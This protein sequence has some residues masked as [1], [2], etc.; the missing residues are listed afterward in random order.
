MGH[1][2]PVPSRYPLSL[3]GGQYKGGCIPQYEPQVLSSREQF[4]ENVYKFIMKLEI[5]LKRPPSICQIQ[6]FERAA[7]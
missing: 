2:T 7:T 3:F 1:A 5:S 4:P 6:P